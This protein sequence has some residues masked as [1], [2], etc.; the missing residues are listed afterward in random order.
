MRSS[1]AGLFFLVLSL[2]L[3]GAAPAAEPARIIW[4]KPLDLAQGEIVELK[5]AGANLVA[6]EGRMGEEAIQFFPNAA[7]SFGALVG[8]DLEAKPGPITILIE[9]T[10]GATRLKKK[11]IVFRI[12][13]KPFPKESFTVPKEFDQ[14]SEEV[15]AR[16]RRERDQFAQAFK[17]SSHQ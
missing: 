16:I 11:E 6:V 14:L 3:G 15:L 5:V 1:R 12:K 17:T 13:S 7:G 2:Q 9:A 8:V 4:P 10:T